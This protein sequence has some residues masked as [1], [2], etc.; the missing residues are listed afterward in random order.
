[1]TQTMLDQIGGEDALRELV[2]HF[3][4]LVETRPEGAHLHHL[5]L[6]SHGIAQTRNEQFEFLSGFMGGRQYYVEKHRH[7]NV[8]EI[9]AHIPIHLDDAENWL[10]LM[11]LALTNLGHRGPHVE[12]LM[13][14]FRRVAQVLINDGKVPGL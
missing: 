11:Q 9:H 3:Y 14:S 4:D 1:M 6:A 2:E 10:S 5:H 12:K 7:M 8:K 13:A